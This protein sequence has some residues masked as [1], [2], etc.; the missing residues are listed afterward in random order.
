ME[1]NRPLA[2][3]AVR[4]KDFVGAPQNPHVHSCTLRFWGPRPASSLGRSRRFCERSVFV[5][6]VVCFLSAPILLAQPPLS[7]LNT[8]DFQKSG[9]NK[10]KWE[11]NPFVQ[12]AETL[13]INELNLM[14]IVYREGDSACLINGQML[15]PGDKIGLAEVVHIEK[16]RVILRNENGI[17]SLA[18]KG[19]SK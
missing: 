19:T 1:K 15:R 9:S 11:K 5:F 7:G 4:P 17:F 12:P 18:L 14:A 8:E 16:K 13:N 10:L 6:F 2:Q 3:P